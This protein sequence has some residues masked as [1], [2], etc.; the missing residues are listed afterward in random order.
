MALS[1]E[2]RIKLNE[3]KKR[4][5]RRHTVLSKAHELSQL[6]E[7][8]EENVAVITYAKGRFTVYL[9]S[10]HPSWPPSLEIIVSHWFWII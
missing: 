4:G 2:Q 7:D 3:R 9:S 1:R 6:G 5:R 10:D 8:G